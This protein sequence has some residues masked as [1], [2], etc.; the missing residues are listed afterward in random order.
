MKKILAII[1]GMI[2]SVIFLSMANAQLNKDI[3]YIRGFVVSIDMVKKVIAVKEGS[4]A[5]SP[6]KTFDISEA[7]LNG[8]LAR[9]QDVF[10]IVPVKSTKAKSVRIIVEKK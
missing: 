4:A 2:F 6:V 3:Q 7:R 1:M 10:V 8:Q 5:N 9:G